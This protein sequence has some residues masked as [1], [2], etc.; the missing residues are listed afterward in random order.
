MNHFGFSPAFVQVDFKFANGNTTEVA[1]LYYLN[2][3]PGELHNLHLTTSLIDHLKGTCLLVN[4]LSQTIKPIKFY[5]RIVQNV[6]YK[7]VSGVT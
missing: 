6:L 4:W 3:L 1:Y 2:D 7:H 5:C